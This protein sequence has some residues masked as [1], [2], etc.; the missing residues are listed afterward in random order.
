MAT[1]IIL[2][3][4]IEANWN[5]DK[6]NVQT[7]EPGRVIVY[8]SEISKDATG[9]DII[10]KLPEG[11]DKPYKHARIKIGDGVT[12][13]SDLPFATDAA[14][15]DYFQAEEGVIYADGGRI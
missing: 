8:D 3:H 11:R 12:P 15:E 2:T 10:A 4:D 6:S 7:L 13:I 1:K 14:I 9:N 5:I